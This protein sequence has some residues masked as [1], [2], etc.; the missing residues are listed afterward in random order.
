MYRIIKLNTNPPRYFH[1]IPMAEDE[2][3]FIWE[4]NSMEATLFESKTKTLEK[5][6]AL[7][8]IL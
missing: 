6:M 4:L 8:F 7:W 1:Y 5:N 3:I 2:H